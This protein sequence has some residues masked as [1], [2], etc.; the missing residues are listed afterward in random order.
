[1]MEWALP[2]RVR[3]RYH[4]VLKEF[5]ARPEVLS[6]IRGGSWRG[7]FRKY[8]ESNL[9]HKKMLRVSARLAATPPRPDGSKSPDELP[10]A[11]DLL[12][13]AQCNDAYW[14]G[15]FRGIYAPHL[16]T[17]PSRN[18]IRAEAIPDRPTP[19]ALF[20]PFQLLYYDPHPPHHSLLTPPTP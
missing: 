12:L 16:P 4:E 14:H 5:S 18:L 10:Q 8:P 15:I 13:R 20:P 11:R 3:Q 6:F 19:R 9:L 17:D 2:T 1:M 7:F